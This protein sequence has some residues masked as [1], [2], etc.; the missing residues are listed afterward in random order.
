MVSRLRNVERDGS[1]LSGLNTF[2]CHA[3]WVTNF[4]MALLKIVP[5]AMMAVPLVRPFGIVPAGEFLN[6]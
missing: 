6:N 1:C 5:E 3:K 4:E 2:P